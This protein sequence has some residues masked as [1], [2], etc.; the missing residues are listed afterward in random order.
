MKKLII[1]LI[2]FSTVCLTAKTWVREYTYNASEADSK[3]TSRAIALEQVKRLLLEELGV[4]VHAT[5]QSEEIEISGEVKELT[6]K[7]IE[8]ISAGITETKIIEETWNGEIYYIRAEIT[9]DENDV[10]KRLDTIIADKEKTKQLEESHQ[11]TEEALTEIERL[12]QQLAQTQDENEKLKIQKKYNLNSNQLTAE[13]WFQKGY[14][15]NEIGEYDNAIL[16]WQKAIEINSDFV[17]A[18]CNMGVAYIYKG[19]YDKAIECFQ[20][21]IALDPNNPTVYDNMGVAYY[22]KENYNIALNFHQKAI[23]IDPN[24]AGAYLNLGLAYYKKKNYDKAINFYQKA[25]SLKPNYA[26]AYNNMGITYID[27]GNFDKAIECLQK[28]CKM[29]TENVDAYNNIGSYIFE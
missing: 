3:I 12:K 15:A 20:K 1:I 23:S 8:I 27:K 29:N 22:D 13:D 21:A 25:I 5:L 10:I 7:Q 6:A 4:Y 14:N 9:A 17:E 24:Y 28:A 2:L 19:N 16:Y 26:D 18:Y 11:R